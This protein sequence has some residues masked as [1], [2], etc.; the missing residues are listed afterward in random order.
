VLD[1]VWFDHFCRLPTGHT[2]WLTTTNKKKD[3]TDGMIMMPV[4]LIIVIV[5]CPEYERD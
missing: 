2:A 5:V 1:V 3:T 4:V